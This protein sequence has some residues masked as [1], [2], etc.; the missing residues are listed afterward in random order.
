LV[1]D[2]EPLRELGAGLLQKF[3]YRV[4]TAVDGEEALKVLSEKTA[5]IDLVILDLIMPGMGGKR[6]LEELIT[7]NP[8]VKVLISSGFA[9]DHPEGKTMEAGAKGFIR[10][11]FDLG[12]MLRAVRDV[13]DEDAAAGDQ[14][15]SAPPRV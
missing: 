2:E 4:L 14:G 12:Q 8:A 13:L 3:G 5:Q 7:M 9:G 15:R 1:D 6:C 11:P 10:K